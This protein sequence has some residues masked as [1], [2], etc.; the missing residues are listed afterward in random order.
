[1]K[2]NSVFMKPCRGLTSQ[3]LVK[4]GVLG[5]AH[6]LMNR[7][8]LADQMT[9]NMHAELE[10]QSDEWLTEH[11]ADRTVQ[12]F[13]ETTVEKVGTAYHNRNCGIDSGL[14]VSCAQNFY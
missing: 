4:I 3:E 14:V 6:P 1:M 7:T 5:L 8:C 11:Q 9:I 13:I 2:A 12:C 10:K